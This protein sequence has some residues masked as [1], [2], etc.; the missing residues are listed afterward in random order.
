MDKII[1][2][3]YILVILTPSFRTHDIIASQGLFLNV[4]N[5][6]VACFILLKGVYKDDSVSK[7]RLNI[8]PIG[9][10]L[11]FIWSILTI[12][13]SIN[14]TESLKT[15]T[16]VFT[17]CLALLNLVFISRYY[18]TKVLVFF[19]LLIGMQLVELGFLYYQFLPDYFDGFSDGINY[20]NYKGLTGNKNIVSFSILLKTPIVLY[21]LFFRKNSSLKKT[22]LWL[23]A[24]LSI[25]IPFVV[26]RTRAAELGVILLLAVY[27]I[28]FVFFKSEFRIHNL[29]S[30]SLLI[31]S[32]FFATNYLAYEQ[33]TLQDLTNTISENDSSKNERLR[34]YSQAINTIIK[35]PFF[36]IGIGNWELESVKADRDNLRTYVVPYHVH[37]D[38]L[39]ITAE[40]GIL[41]FLLYFGPL[42]L[43][44]IIFIKNI[45]NKVDSKTLT[46]FLCFSIF[47]LDSL[48][49][50]PFARVIMN[51]NL[52]FLLIL[53]ISYISDTD[54]KIFSSILQKSSFLK[55][56]FICLLI[57]TPLSLYSS[58]RMFNSSEDQ[59]YL[60][61]AFNQ[62]N[63]QLIP[64]EELEKMDTR[65]PNITGTSMSLD[66][67][68]GIH[69]Y[70]RGDY[71]KARNRFRNAIKDNPYMG[72]GEAYL[73]GIHYNEK[74]IDSS[75]Y[76]GQ[77]AFN[78]GPNNPVHFY[79]L[80]KPL[81][82]LKDTLKIKELYKSI[83]SKEDDR[84]DQIYLLAMSSL[85][86]KDEGNFVLNDIEGDL[87]SEKN[88]ESYY[89][90]ELGRENVEKG[91][92]N[93]LIGNTFMEKEQFE[94][95]A[96]SY[97][98]AFNYNPLELP[99]LENS[100]IAYFKAN[101]NKQA[102]ENINLLISKLDS[103]TKNGKAYYL[104]AILNLELGNIDK[105]CKDLEMAK[106]LNFEI[107]NLIELYCN[108]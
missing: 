4:L 51:I 96:A 36:G 25:I 37:N 24:F 15:L 30:L 60:L 76:Y 57:L 33:N 93:Y 68:V 12:I 99:Y 65:Y 26:T 81:S 106:K 107:G 78:K 54:N 103:N 32:L 101:K 62:N 73:S 31:L 55:I 77:L 19:K 79:Y 95:A 8:V 5:V 66:A 102:F 48:F 69:Y 34:Y 13:K 43:I 75:L 39:E 1:Y 7:F 21:F 98:L 16:E 80:L 6:I 92:I 10:I 20:M 3:L 14:I 94:E 84:I 59:L 2:I 11:F 17:V 89:V 35:N 52:I 44:F 41:G 38:F 91:Y 72:I 85:M 61:Y 28:Y 9:I 53:S 83:P 90:L 40:T 87:R 97:E 29:G 46:L 104:R 47:F 88:I 70:H 45:K 86:D 56:S 74:N 67:I 71:K 64:N 100:V 108:N 18:K 42:F 63:F 49:N 27:S 82:Y 105:S 22:L 58:I 50:F 23:I